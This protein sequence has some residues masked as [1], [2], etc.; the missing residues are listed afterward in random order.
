MAEEER[1]RRLE[2]GGVMLEEVESLTK[3]IDF[4]HLVQSMQ[5]NNMN[6]RIGS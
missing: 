3:E 6:S 1:K 2:L 4:R 5:R